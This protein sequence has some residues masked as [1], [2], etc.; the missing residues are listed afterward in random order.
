MTAPKNTLYHSELV[1][2]SAEG[3][4][5]IVVKKKAQKSRYAKN[6]P[7]IEVEL[8]GYSRRYNCENQRCMEI[9]NRHVGKRIVATFSGR[10]ET[11]DVE[12]MVGQGAPP[13]QQGQGGWNSDPNE[14]QGGAF[15]DADPVPMPDQEPPPRQQA[16]PPQQQPA[17]QRRQAPPAPPS[18]NP[19]PS[20]PPGGQRS[21]GQAPTGSAKDPNNARSQLQKAANL[22]WKCYALAVDGGTEMLARGYDVP[23]E[24]MRSA[25]STLFIFATGH[26]QEG[27]QYLQ[28]IHEAC[29]DAP[30]FPKSKNEEG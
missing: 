23:G 30:V 3:P 26:R 10:D 18:E 5:N 1:R 15:E 29:S 2:L 14:P 25:A 13:Q 8:E 16:P 20:E 9:L 11:A 28:S 4:V 24:A 27:R 6:P 12:V 19:W 7:Y 17:Q 22:Y 21:Q